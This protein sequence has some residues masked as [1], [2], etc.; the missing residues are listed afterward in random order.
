M[1]SYSTILCCGAGRSTT[2]HLICADQVDP[3]IIERVRGGCSLC[4]CLTRRDVKS[5]ECPQVPD[6]EFFALEQA[7]LT[8]E[9]RHAAATSSGDKKKE[10]PVVCGAAI[11]KSTNFSG[12]CKKRKLPRSFAHQEHQTAPATAPALHYTVCTRRFSGKSTHLCHPADIDISRLGR[13][14]SMLHQPRTSICGHV[15]FD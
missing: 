9:S 5:L 13:P 2:E 10:S 7:I 3:M 12:D 1:S 15:K 6:A 14:L 4:D 8:A 11:S